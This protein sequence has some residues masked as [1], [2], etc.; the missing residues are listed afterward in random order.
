M[1]NVN[2]HVRLWYAVC[3]QVFPPQ[4]NNLKIFELSLPGSSKLFVF[5]FDHSISLQPHLFLMSRGPPSLE[6]FK[7]RLDKV[8][9][10]LL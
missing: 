3:P 7:A 10:S 9:C 2:V 5:T 6:I 4:Q 8:L 1:C